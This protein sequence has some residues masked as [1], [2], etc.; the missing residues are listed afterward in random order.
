MLSHFQ[1]VIQKQMLQEVKSIS[2]KIRAEKRYN[3]GAK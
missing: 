1:L 2:N 3:M